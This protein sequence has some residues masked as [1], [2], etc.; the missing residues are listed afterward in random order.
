MNSPLYNYQQAKVV[1]LGDA[2][3]G[4]SCI[5]ERFVSDK[6]SSAGGPTLGATF[7]SKVLDFRTITLKLN[8]WD[9]AGQ[10]R[11]SSISQNFCRDSDICIL[12]YDISDHHSFDSLKKWHESIRTFLSEN[13]VLAVVGNKQDL[14]NKEAVS[15]MEAQYFSNS[16]RA[17]FAKTS[18][19]DGV[20]ITELFNEVSKKFLGYDNL[21]FE[22]KKTSERASFYLSSSKSVTKP[23]KKKCCF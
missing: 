5:I 4:K 20:G 3:V 1:F 16:I 9:T 14:S 15:E 11:F 18:A 6:F 17:I 19:K 21:S 7:L 23:K 2:R 22:T 13:T 10:E 12:V 8:I